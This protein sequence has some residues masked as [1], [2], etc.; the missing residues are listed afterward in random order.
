MLK[1]AGVVDAGGAGYLLLLD[2]ALHVV[3]GEP[4]PEPDIVDAGA[5]GRR[6][7]TTVAHRTSGVDGELDVS[8][9]RYEVMFL[10]D[11]AD[12]RID[13]LKNGWGEIGDS[14]VVV[15]GDGI[16]NCHVHTNDIGAAIEVGARR[17]RPAVP[18][19]RHRPRSRRSPPSTPSARRASPRRCGAVADAGGG[20]AD[21]D[22][23]PVD[24][25]GR[26]RQQRR[27]DLRDV[28][29]PRRAGRRAR[30][31]RR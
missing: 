15:G 29:R 8:E 20:D 25:R 2:S 31:A 18:D 4:L 17:R 28:P 11:L 30:R 3:D 27:G 26:R 23:P 22:L 19:P 1:D 12:E 13:D 24:V 7:S 21:A 6:R 9:Q 16:W 5:V 14:I 10:C